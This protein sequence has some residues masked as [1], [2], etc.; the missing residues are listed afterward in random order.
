LFTISL[1]VPLVALA[2]VAYAAPARL[3]ARARAAL[4][5]LRAPLR[6]AGSLR[7]RGMAVTAVGELDV[8]IR[9]SVTAGALARAGA[10][11]RTSLPGLHTA[12]VPAAALDRIASL[13]GVESIRAAARAEPE[14]SQS[15]PTTGAPLLRGGGPWFP[16][17]N[18]AGVL[19]GS[20]DTGMDFGHGDF[21]DPDGHT[22]FVA[23]WDQTATGAGTPAYPY[24]AFWSRDAIDAGLC[25]EADSVGHGTHV[26]GIAAGDGS[27]T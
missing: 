23:I 18:G 25:T 13:P 9:G 7:A 21:M 14:L 17:L 2:C 6:D 20:V 5:A 3:D 19:V 26:L 10:R 1:L 27:Q 22:R 24:G 11:V 15:V 12:F 16:G 8:V 4:T